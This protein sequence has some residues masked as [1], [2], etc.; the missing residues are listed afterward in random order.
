M[1]KYDNHLTI[2]IYR[3]QDIL[4]VLIIKNSHQFRKTVDKMLVNVILAQK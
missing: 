1:I 3:F 2:V 4:V